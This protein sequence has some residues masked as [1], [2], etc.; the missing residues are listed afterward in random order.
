M[1]L[2]IKMTLTK[3]I[4][5]SFALL[6]CIIGLIIISVYPYSIQSTLKENTYRT[7]E[8]QQMLNF[9]ALTGGYGVDNPG[10]QVHDQDSTSSIWTLMVNNQFQTIIGHAPS[11]HSV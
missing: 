4:W 1:K 5:L 2:P 10:T 11:Y 7:I 8:V 9:Q 3:R 6:E